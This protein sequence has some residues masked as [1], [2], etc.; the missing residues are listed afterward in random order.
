MLKAIEIIIL[1][2]NTIFMKHLIIALLFFSTI[3]HAKAQ[4]INPKIQEFLGNKTNEIAQNEPYRIAALTDLLDNRIKIVESPIVGEDKYVKVFSLGLM[5][6]YNP[7]MKRDLVFDI[8]TFNPLKY[9]MNFFT[10]ETQVYR[11]DNT[12]Y[13]IV[14]EKQNIK[15]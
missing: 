12:N 5:D 7:D 6:K 11:I 8:N 9:N 13:I 1:K 2:L 15:H 4:D 3:Y 14:I 10:S